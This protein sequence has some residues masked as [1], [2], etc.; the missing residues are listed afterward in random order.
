[1][2]GYLSDAAGM[3]MSF[4]VKECQMAMEE[5]LSEDFIPAFTR[6]CGMVIFERGKDAECVETP[7]EKQ[8]RVENAIEE[9]VQTM[10]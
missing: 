2:A 4:K 3:P 10:I 7:S 5:L 9:V 1:M 6:R 8:E